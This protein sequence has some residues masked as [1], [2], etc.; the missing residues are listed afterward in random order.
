M[1]KEQLL[2]HCHEAVKTEETAT[3]VYLKHLSAI[4][5]RSG[6]PKPDIAKIKDTIEFLIAMNTRHKELMQSLINRIQEED[7]DVY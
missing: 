7:I 3:T 5:F 2:K 4:V 1:K 6:L